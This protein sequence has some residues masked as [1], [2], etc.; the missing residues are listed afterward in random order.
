MIRYTHIY[1]MVDKRPWPLMAGLGGFSLT[2]GL[3]GSFG[4]FGPALFVIG[5]VLIVVTMIIWWR[6][7]IREGTYLGLHSNEVVIG[8]RWGMVLFI[9]SEV[10]FFVSFFWAFFHSSLCPVLEVGSV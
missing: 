5:L 8:L 6:D 7:V 1:H 9:V 2:S 3:V 4:G 10:F